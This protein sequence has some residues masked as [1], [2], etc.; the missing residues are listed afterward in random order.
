MISFAPSYPKRCDSRRVVY[1]VDRHRIRA[2]T[3]EKDFFGLPVCFDRAVIVEVVVGQIGKDGDLIGYASNAILVEG[4]RGHL[5]YARGAS[6][7][8]HFFQGSVELEGVGGRQG[9]VDRFV[10]RQDGDGAHESRLY[11]ENREQVVYEIGGG[12]FTVR[13]RY[14][15]HPETL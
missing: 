2:K 5:H 14:A 4:M 13:T 10:A 3:V 9:G 11:A 7:L 15:D 8:D 1:V 6:G 12:R